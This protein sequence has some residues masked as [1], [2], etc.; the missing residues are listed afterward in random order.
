M[1]AGEGVEAKQGRHAALQKGLHDIAFAGGTV[2][3]T[4]VSSTFFCVFF[5]GFAG[6][7]KKLMRRDKIF[8]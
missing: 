1:I 5:S 6:D 4:S 2:F 7:K 3:W 8:H